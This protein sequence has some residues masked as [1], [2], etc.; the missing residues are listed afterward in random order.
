MN[1]QDFLQYKKLLDTNPD[2]QQ[3]LQQEE[4]QHH[5]QLRLPVCVGVLRD[6]LES[7]RL[8]LNL[9]DEWSISA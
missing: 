5:P 4:N 3:Q 7:F 9:A 1:E 2:L 8:D 6:L